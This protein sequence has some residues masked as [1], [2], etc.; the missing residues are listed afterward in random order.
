MDCQGTF[1][2]PVLTHKLQVQSLRSTNHDVITVFGL[3][4]VN[5]ASTF[6]SNTSF[7]VAAIETRRLTRGSA[8]R[9]FQLPV[10]VGH[11]ALMAEGGQILQLGLLADRRAQHQSRLFFHQMAIACRPLTK[12]SLHVAQITVR[13]RIVMLAMSIAATA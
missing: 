9:Q 6:V 10:A 11:E 7:A 8:R 12:P 4:R 5:S 1:G 2:D 13:L 3:D